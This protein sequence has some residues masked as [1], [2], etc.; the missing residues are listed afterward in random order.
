LIGVPAWLIGKSVVV[1]AWKYVIVWPLTAGPKKPY[2]IWPL[3]YHVHS[4]ALGIL[5]VV[6]WGIAAIAILAAAALALAATALALAATGTF[7]YWTWMVAWRK[8]HRPLLKSWSSDYK[9]LHYWESPKGKYVEYEKLQPL[10]R[11][12]LGNR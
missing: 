3:V 11:G 1:G 6:G 12:R 9:R 5:A 4:V 7:L 10:V 8:K 2:S